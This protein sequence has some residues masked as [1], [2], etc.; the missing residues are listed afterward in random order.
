MLA[1]KERQLK[2]R[3]RVTNDGE[4]GYGEGVYIMRFEYGRNATYYDNIMNATPQFREAVESIFSN[5]IGD[6][7]FLDIY[8]DPGQITLF[9]PET[10]ELGYADEIEETEESIIVEISDADHEQVETVIEKIAEFVIN[11]IEGKCYVQIPFGEYE[12]KVEMWGAE[13][14]KEVKEFM[15]EN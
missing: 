5:T 3:I 9:D 11:E 7:D 1:L 14:P 2:V 15:F 4:D 13:C 10:G 8:L 6:D 12:V